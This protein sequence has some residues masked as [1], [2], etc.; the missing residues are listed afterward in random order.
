M[1]TSEW[2]KDS[3]EPVS[4]FG[5]TTERMS[6]DVERDQLASAVRPALSEESIHAEGDT[7]QS[8][9]DDQPP[10]PGFA[11]I[12]AWTGRVS[13]LEAVQKS[14]GPTSP[15]RRRG[16]PYNLEP[17]DPNVRWWCNP[18]AIVRLVADIRGDTTG[19]AILSPK[20]L[21]VRLE[22]K[23]AEHAII[24][25]DGVDNEWSEALCAKYPQHI[26]EKFLL[27]HVLGVP[28]PAECRCLFGKSA[29]CETIATDLERVTQLLHGRLESQRVGFHVNYLLK[30]ELTTVD[31][32]PDMGC[33]LRRASEK[34]WSN[35]LISCCNLEGNLC[36]CACRNTII[37]FPKSVSRS[38][39]RQPHSIYK[40]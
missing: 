38:C 14:V 17:R 21:W 12:Y 29:T 27:E 25:I 33:I 26:N 4:G 36:K 3:K 1:M 37:T 31:P 16:H 8:A 39:T 18:Q 23:T 34:S 7:T 5:Q 10:L 15:L 11:Q 6:V 35:G 22:A 32:N 19:T 24:V 13:L 20:D 40:T 2:W 28:V 30:P 9:D